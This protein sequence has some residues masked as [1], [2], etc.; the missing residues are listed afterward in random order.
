MIQW[1]FT[2]RW[3]KT[4]CVTIL[5]VDIVQSFE[6]NMCRFIL[7]LFL[8]VMIILPRLPRR[9]CLLTWCYLHLTRLIPGVFLTLVS[10]D[11]LPGTTPLN[12]QCEDIPTILSGLVGSCRGGLNHIYLTGNCCLKMMFQESFAL[13]ISI[14]VIFNKIIFH[15]GM[16]W[17]FS[18]TIWEVHLIFLV[19]PAAWLSVRGVSTLQ[20]SVEEDGPTTVQYYLLHNQSGLARLLSNTLM[21]MDSWWRCTG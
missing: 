14:C 1:T 19:I 11:L 2:L 13:G 6:R 12:H 4:S 20:T 18:E 21:I 5:R 17:G 7:T 15:R 10:L 8:D 9:C 16:F 3:F